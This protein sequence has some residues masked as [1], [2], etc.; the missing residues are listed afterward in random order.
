M[1]AAAVVLLSSGQANAQQLTI[2]TLADPTLDPHFVYLGSN[3]AVW[4]HFFTTLTMHDDDGNIIPNLAQSWTAPDDRTWQFHLR[5]DAKFKDGA[6]VTADDVV[7]SL[8]RVGSVQGNPAPYTPAMQAIT[9]FE[10]VDPVTVR[11]HTAVVAPDVPA[12]LMEI[13]IVSRSAVSGKTT[14][15]FNSLQAMRENGPFTVASFAQGD[16]LVLQRNPNYWGEKSDWQQVTIRFMSSNASRV[17]ALLSGDVDFIDTVPPNDAPKLRANPKIAVQDGPSTRL[18]IVTIN[19]RPDPIPTVSDADGKPLSVNPLTDVRVRQAL[20]KAFDRAALVEKIMDG[21]A[22]ATS[23]YAIQGLVGFDPDLPVEKY[24]PQGAK[25]LLAAAGY[26]RGFGLNINCS[27]NRY[28][29][30]E[31]ICQALGQMMT[32]VGLQAKVETMPVAMLTPLLRGTPTEP[33]KVALGLNGIGAISNLPPVPGFVVHSINPAVGRGGSNY[34]RFSDPALDR[35]IDEAIATPDLRLRDQ[36]LR[37]AMAAARREVPVVPLYFQKVITASR[38][39]LVFDTNPFEETLAW[40]IH[41]R[42]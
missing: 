34:G 25:G 15:D 14:S 2:G 24:D 19:V 32:R 4:R 18:L 39:D 1:L 26:P 23:Q 42:P 20:S 28:P 37:D 22:I 21:E 27:N 7:F 3:I 40:H 10:V 11:V 31:K 33:S 30:D 38:A 41:Q 8:G 6:R 5:P 35:S 9:S 13:A 16:R 29:N 36:R 12:N 17:A